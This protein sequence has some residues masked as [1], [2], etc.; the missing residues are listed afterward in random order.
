MRLVTAAEALRSRGQHVDHK[1]FESRQCRNNKVDSRP[2]RQLPSQR[3]GC[4][5][6]SQTGE[7]QITGRRAAQAASTG[8]Y[9]INACACSFQSR[10][11]SPSLFNRSSFVPDSTTPDSSMYLCTGQV[12][13]N[14]GAR[15]RC[16][17]T[18]HNIK[19]ACLVRL[20]KRCDEN[21]IVLL[22]LIS[23]RRSNR[24]S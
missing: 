15:E 2:D 3:D 1:Q 10:A 18:T 4:R 24:S 20:P 7:L 22:P 6:R 21:T 12:G 17:K 5:E 19:S 8:D 14:T 16:D 13:T 11:Y 9:E 23:R